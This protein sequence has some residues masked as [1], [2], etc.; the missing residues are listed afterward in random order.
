MPERS[1]PSIGARLAIFYIT[2]GALLD[3]WTAIY[4][5]FYL[6]RQVGAGDNRLFWCV[7]LFFTG[8]TLMVIGFTLG[9]IGR[10]ARHA[11]LPPDPVKVV[12]PPPA[13]PPATVPAVPSAV[14]PVAPVQTVPVVPR[15][16]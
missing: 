14:P 9:R 4:Y 8:V 1:K 5:S 16:R 2:I 11:D 7:G 13:S 3:V 6:H 10:S 12:A 15:P